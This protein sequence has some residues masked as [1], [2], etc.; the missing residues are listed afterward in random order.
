MKYIKTTSELAAYINE[1][2]MYK[3]IVN[4][5]SSLSVNNIAKASNEITVDILFLS[6]MPNLNY[7]RKEN[8]TLNRLQSEVCLLMRTDKKFQD[9]E[10]VS[11]KIILIEDEVVLKT[12]VETIYSE[13]V[14]NTSNFQLDFFPMIGKVTDAFLSY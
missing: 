6:V 12:T 9:I 7:L 4:K 1:E 8:K 2:L 5:E 3:E 13:V 11:T 10:F 14:T